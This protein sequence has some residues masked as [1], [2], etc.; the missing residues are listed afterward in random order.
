MAGPHRIAVFVLAED[1]L[2]PVL[3]G[4]LVHRDQHRFLARY[5]GQNGLSQHPSQW[6]QRPTP[7]AQHAV[8]AAE[9][10][11]HQPRH[12]CQHVGHGPQAW[13]NDGSEQQ[14][15]EAVE[16]GLVNAMRNCSTSGA[17]AWGN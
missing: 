5:P 17:S 14:Q 2:A 3:G 10:S 16:G 11:A 13:G 1:L 15:P 12:R 6:P 9:V 7:L 4:V 8:V